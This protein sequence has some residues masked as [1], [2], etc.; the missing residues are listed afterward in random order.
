VDLRTQRE[1]LIDIEE[2]VERLF[3]DT[4]ELRRHEH[5]RPQKRELL[6]RIF[7]H[8]HSIKG[9]ASTAGLQ[10]VGKLAHQTESLLDNARVGRVPIEDQLIDTVEQAANAISESLS[11]A[12]AGLAAAGPPAELI[13]SFHDIKLD[14]AADL[15]APVPLLP[16]DLA[17][18]IN[19]RERQLIQAALR[20]NEKL[21]LIT[22]DFA[23]MDFDKGFHEL[24]SVLTSEG[25]VISSLPSADSA[26]PDR[27]VFRILCSSA[28]AMPALERQLGAFPLASITPL[29]TEAGSGPAEPTTSKR[30]RALP[31]DSSVR[32]QIEELDRLISSA[33]ELFGQTV[34]AL[35][36][37]S[38][39][40]AADARVEL[41]NLDAQIR[42]SLVALEERIIQLRMVPLERVLQRALRAGRV[43]AKVSGKEVEFITAGEQLRIDKTVCDAVADPLLHLVRNAVDQ[44]I[45]T[46]DERRQLGKPAVGSV[47]I[48]ATSN[49][50][51]V[52]FVVSDDGRGIDP[53]LVSKAAAKLG[54]V[55]EGT[56]L[57]REMSLRMIFRPG[58]STVAEVSNLSGRGVGLDIVESSIERVG[59]AVRVHTEVGRG[60]EF[61][62]RLPA[63]LGVMRALVLGSGEH[64]YC[65]DA[66]LVVDQCSLQTSSGSSLDWRNQT[67]P[68]VSLGEL[69]RQPAGETGEDTHALV[70]SCF[71]EGS[72]GA[73]TNH[74]A[75]GVESFRGAQEVLVRSL[76]Q[77][78]A[79]W[80]GVVGATELWDGAVALVL[81]LPLLLAINSTSA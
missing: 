4:E 8:V 9:V 10:D 72:E 57:S 13:Q 40:L 44:G 45:E 74:H 3:A 48:E 63:S 71:E 47:R 27:V 66:G 18:S 67:L 58:F 33:H 26:R 46:P 51:R 29:E 76:G 55:D 37:V 15:E 42:E 23:L 68:L 70:C 50:G 28:L 2:L 11:A 1:F 12:V 78:S 35:D 49:A 65:V 31:T 32:I 16:D 30:A 7:R 21:Y 36:L 73:A 62:I 52:R 80:P 54:L 61:E 19:E 5:S 69:I 34:A 81:D 20:E 6:D 53:Q 14:E 39:T 64:L 43:A 79:L 75:I 60:T 24:R 77:H 59:G 25:T 38:A 41:R 56:I 22:V 17:A